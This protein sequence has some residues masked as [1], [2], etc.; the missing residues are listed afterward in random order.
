V[1]ELRRIQHAS[2][3]AGTVIAERD[4]VLTVEFDA[5][6]I[7]KVPS[8]E[9]DERRSIHDELVASAWSP[10]LAVVTRALAAAIRSTND[11]WGVFSPSRIAVLPHQ[12]WVCQRVLRSWPSRWLIADDVGLGKTVEAGLILTPLVSRGHV[13]RLLVMCP[14]SLTEQWQERLREMF[15]LRMALY[16]PEVDSPKSDFWQ[17][18]PQVV[19]SM[20]TLRLDR[21]ERWDRM[22]D[23]PRW[24]LVLVD[25][26]HHLSADD[27][28][29]K[30]LGLQLL[31]K[32]DERG[33][34]GGLLL[35]TGTPHRGKDFGFLSL[36]RLVDR[37]IEPR[38]GLE[39]YLSRLPSIVIRNNKQ[40]V[41]D[42]LGAKLFQPVTVSDATYSYSPEEAAFYAKLTEFIQTGRAYAG[43]MQ[44]DTQR[45][46]M[47]VL[48]TMQKLASS[49]VAAVL[50]ALDGRLARLRAQESQQTSRRA[51]LARAWRELE[52]I[53]PEIES[54]RR[55][56]LEE[57]VHELMDGVQLN[58]DEIPALEELVATA[59]SV[60][61]ESRVERLM[62]LVASLPPDEA[63]L[64]FTE[65][66]ATQALVVSTLTRRFGAASVGFINGD[67]ELKGVVGSD[68]EKRTLRAERAAAAQRFNDGE[69]RFLVSTEAAG[70]GIDLQRSCRRLVHVDIPW[71]PMRMHQRVG[72]INRYGQTRPVEVHIVRNPT[73]IES[74]I[75]ELLNNKLDRIAMTF[76]GAMAD[77]E[78]IRALVLGLVSSGTHERIAARALDV[79]AESFDRWYDAETATFGGESA[80]AAVRA[81]LGNVARFDFQS[82]SRE[83]PRVDLPDLRPFLRG[84][85]R[86]QQRRADEKDEGLLSFITPKV[87]QDRHPAVRERYEV[88]FDRAR[89]RTIRGP[90]LVGA[91]HRLMEAALDEAE[92]RTEQA[93]TVAGLSVPL[94]VFVCSDD[95]SA[96]SAA[97]RRMVFGVDLIAGAPKVLQDW[98]L[99][100]RLNTLL[101]K[102][103]RAGLRESPANPGADTPSKVS[104]AVEWFNQQLGSLDMPFRKPVARL[105]SVLWP[106]AS[107]S[108]E[109][110]T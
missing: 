87:W 9:V 51:A 46:V 25:E 95:V 7:L 26:A 49:S 102:P 109:L 73:T 21:D 59:T 60:V 48:T 3:G 17:V 4:D 93:S 67:G 1:T 40:N 75:W 71:N 86:L 74:R 91:G 69:L 13:K 68:G 104:A 105:H 37:D 90:T 63:V 110:R 27:N 58:P 35:F 20:H 80:V 97:I 106:D 36:L 45:Q 101:D 31:E 28:G 108:K 6:R 61:S 34:I 2:F 55:T 65:Y 79:N 41:C 32:L 29:K 53:D 94:A 16:H 12:L 103:D 33:L 38:R 76:E 24:D 88:H 78:D 83:V 100:L 19:A 85:L 96:P 5:G 99:V 81:L 82:A 54:E 50:R 70:E 66:K 64:F 52:G 98:E 43:S 14:A 30:T 89:E 77:P 8:G 92:E 72:R 47:L 56:R 84:A 23:A 10:P 39:P 57:Q 22:L 44:R 107:G 11:R 42:M 62:E 18:H 15:D